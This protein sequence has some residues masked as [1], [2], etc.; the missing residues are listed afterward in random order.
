M[1]A[2][3]NLNQQRGFI[4]PVGMVM[5]AIMTVL[6]VSS[7]RDSALQERM[8]SNFIDKE[9]SFQAAESALRI[10]QRASIRT[11]YETIAA[12]PDFVSLTTNPLDA[13]DFSDPDLVDW[14]AVAGNPLDTFGQP[15]NAVADITDATANANNKLFR[16]PRA[17]IEEL[18]STDSLKIGK[19][20]ANADLAKRYYRVTAYANGETPTARTTVQ[21]V[22]LQE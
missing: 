7:M 3:K 12:T 4:L 2:P 17:V 20:K 19:E 21:S 6:G 18:E 15:I 10:V 5:L 1:N 14:Y 22:V 9:K 11:S 8:A 16:D 13:I